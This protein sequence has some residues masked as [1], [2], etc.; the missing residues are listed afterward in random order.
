MFCIN[1]RAKLGAQMQS[2][3]STNYWLLGALKTF[4][5]RRLRNFFS[6]TGRRGERIQR[7]FEGKRWLCRKSNGI[8]EFPKNKKKLFWHILDNV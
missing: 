1:K 6:V 7:Y 4:S 3:I 8:L 2:L 5:F